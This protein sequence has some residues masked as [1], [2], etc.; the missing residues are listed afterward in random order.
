[1]KGLDKNEIFKILY[2]LSEDAYIITEGGKIIEASPPALELLGVSKKD[3]YEKDALQY[4]IPEHRDMV[5]KMMRTK[6]I[7]NYKTYILNSSFEEIAVQINAKNV[8]LNGRLIRVAH[9]YDLRLE[10]KL[11]YSEELYKSIF[12]TTGT[13]ILIF[14]DHRKIISVNNAFCS[15]VGLKKEDIIGRSWE[16]FVHEDSKEEML[17]NNKLRMMGSPLPPSSYEFK[18]IGDNG[19]KFYECKLI[20]RLL[21]NK[22]IG[23]ASIIDLTE[24]KKLEKELFMFNDMLEGRLEEQAKEIIQSVKYTEKLEEEREKQNNLLVQQYKLASMGEMIGN[25]AHQWR[26]PLNSLG[27]MLFNL[28]SEFDDGELTK[29]GME[30]I[31]DSMRAQIDEM[32]KTIDDF[33][34][35]Y[36]P[37]KTKKTF[38][39]SKSLQSAI[40]IL[41]AQLN[42]HQI[43]LNTEIDKSIEIYGYEGEL[44]QVFINI[45]N[46]AKDEILKRDIKGH[47]TVKAYKDNGSNTI[48]DIEDNGGGIAL[49]YIDKLFEPYFTTKSEGS[50]TGIGLYMCKMIV[51]KSMNGMLSAHNIEDGARFRIKF[52]KHLEEKG[53]LC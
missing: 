15:M 34:Y 1:M 13:A 37:L 10:E 24:T 41:S 5:R 28:Y 4:V 18:L 17:R 47:I 12:E 40:S 38:R 22:N 51:E 53:K 19:R 33:R 42:N 25:I 45:I 16:Q 21:H 20:I 39:L 14:D 3:T 49:E 32:S 31:Y 35:F 30:K 26:Q 36:K 46:N 52:F 44:S 6:G 48:I 11:E 7:V 50:G 2:E 27:L 43:K 9:I 29:E 23:I 8:S